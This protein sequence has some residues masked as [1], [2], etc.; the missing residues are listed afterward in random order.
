MGG[1]VWYRSGHA[2]LGGGAG[3]SA[4]VTNLGDD[5]GLKHDSV[6]VG[7]ILKAEVVQSVFALGVE[8]NVDVLPTVSGKDFIAPWPMLMFTFGVGRY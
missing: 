1:L 7:T 8:L 6:G 5:H 4:K 3:F 2:G